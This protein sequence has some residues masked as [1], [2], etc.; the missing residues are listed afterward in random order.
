MAAKVILKFDVFPKEK[1]RLEIICKSLDVTKI[2][3]LR[4]AM[5]EAELK[6]ELERGN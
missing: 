4:Q 2:E 3:F 1:E 5:R 6:I